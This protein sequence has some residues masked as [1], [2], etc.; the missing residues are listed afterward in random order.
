MKKVTIINFDKIRIIKEIR[1]KN[2]DYIYRMIDDSLSRYDSINVYWL[3]SGKYRVSILIDGYWVNF[4]CFK[5][6]IAPIFTPV[7]VTSL[8]FA[9]RES[10]FLLCY[11][12]EDINHEKF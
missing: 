1:Y 10:L 6:N 8:E 4:K 3:K 9:M 2:V 5:I 7:Q 12:R 11:V